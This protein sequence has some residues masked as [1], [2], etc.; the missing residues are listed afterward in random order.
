M[1]PFLFIFANNEL[2]VA[3]LKALRN[4]FTTIHG[5]DSKCTIQ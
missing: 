2:K 5:D 4:M 1:L 3:F